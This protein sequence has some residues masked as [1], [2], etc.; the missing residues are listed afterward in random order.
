MLNE[1]LHSAD[2]MLNMVWQEA[3]RDILLHQRKENV[4]ERS[5]GRKEAVKTKQ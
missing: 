5:D 4:K 1:I 2:L 3:G